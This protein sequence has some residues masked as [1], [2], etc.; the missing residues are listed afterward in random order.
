MKE[1][2]ISVIIPTLN[3]EAYIEAT[4]RAIKNQDYKG[5]YEVIVADGMSKDSTLKIAR[6]Y[7]DKV[8]KIK[9][10]GVSVGRNA[11]AKIARGDIFLFID[12]DTVAS[13]NLLAEFAKSFNKKVVGVTCPVLPLSSNATDFI[14]YWF[15]NQFVKTSVRTRKPHV[16][17]ICC[18]YRREAFEKIGGFNENL[19]TVEDFDF[20]ER[21]SKLGKITIANSTFVMTSPRRIERWGKTKAAARYIKIYLNYLLVGKTVGIDKYRPIR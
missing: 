6:K 13:F 11:G 16:A 4:L 10:R 9:K 20:S 17:G 5:G 8:I 15:Y 3:E 12:A 7:A 19:K 18:A 1:P 14:V 2:F 21:I